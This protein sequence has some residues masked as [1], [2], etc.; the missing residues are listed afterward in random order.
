M[1]DTRQDGAPPRRLGTFAIV[2]GLVLVADQLTKHWALNRLSDGQMIDVV[3]SLRF[4]LLKNTGAAFSLGSGSGMGPWISVVAIGVVV[5]L[6]LGQT[7]RFTLG[8]A[9]AGMIAG[10]AIG[11]L[12]DRALRGD[13]GFLHGAVIDFID[14]QWWPVFNVADAGVVVGAVLLVVASFKNPVPA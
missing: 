9:A 11:N 3:G 13:D 5:M 1:A 8:A 14:L 4:N 10:G 7:S 6:A 12:L 2:G